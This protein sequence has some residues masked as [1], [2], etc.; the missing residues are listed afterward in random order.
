MGAKNKAIKAKNFDAVVGQSRNRLSR[1][2]A[3]VFLPFFLFC[4]L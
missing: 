2:K 1:D 4:S 3:F